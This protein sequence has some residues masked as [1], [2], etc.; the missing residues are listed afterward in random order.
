VG[1]DFQFA[2][3]RAKGRSLPFFPLLQLKDRMYQNATRMGVH[4]SLNV[5]KNFK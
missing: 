5:D 4:N 1:Y 3:T 2:D